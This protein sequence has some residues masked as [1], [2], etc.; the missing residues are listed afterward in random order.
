MGMKMLFKGVNKRSRLRHTCNT[1]IEF[2]LNSGRAGKTFIGAGVN[3]SDLGM[4]IYTFDR[5][6]E[7]ETIEIIKNFPVPYR[8]A[9][10]R[11]V[12][13]CCEDFYKI[14]ITFVE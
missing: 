6:H 5:L 14:G 12:K 11:W 10:V 4:C 9:T 7:G 8:K 3:I 1:V 13:E 2:R